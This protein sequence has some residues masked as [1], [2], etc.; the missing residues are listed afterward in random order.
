[1]VLHIE[2]NHPPGRDLTITKLID[3]TASLLKHFNHRSF[4][5]TPPEKKY[6]RREFDPTA[7]GLEGLE[8]DSAELYM[9]GRKIYVYYLD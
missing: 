4:L 7:R 9:V 5:L 8:W 6:E 1:M 3:T 2:N